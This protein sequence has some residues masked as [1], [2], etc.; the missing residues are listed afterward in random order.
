MCP[1]RQGGCYTSQALWYDTL[2]SLAKLRRWYP[3]DVA[4]ANQW[5]NLLKSEGLERIA[6]K[7]LVN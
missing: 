2:A 3:G 1:N 4:I 6:G 7:P 5:K